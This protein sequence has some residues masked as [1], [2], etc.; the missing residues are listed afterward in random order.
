MMSNT[1]EDQGKRESVINML[2]STF[3]VDEIVREIKR[4]AC[5]NSQIDISKTLYSMANSCLIHG[6]Y[7]QEVCQLIKGVLSRG[8]A[9]SMQRYH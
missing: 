8:C 6:S 5:K 7:K 4:K 1:N 9:C 3:V 2:S